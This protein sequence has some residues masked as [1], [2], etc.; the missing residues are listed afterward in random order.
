V[1]RRMP[2]LQPRRSHKV[3]KKTFR[4]PARVME[5]G[6]TALMP[7]KAASKTA[8]KGKKAAKKTSR[9]SAKRK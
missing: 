7:K 9:K 4:S 8:K 3:T 1:K 2:M 6:V 5:R